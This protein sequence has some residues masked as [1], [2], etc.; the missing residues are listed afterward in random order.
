VR[1]LVL[2]LTLCCALAF[3]F[4]GCQKA[5]TDAGAGPVKGSA[6]PANAPKVADKATT[7]TKTLTD[8][9]GKKLILKSGGDTSFLK[10]AG[11][12]EYPGATAYAID[13]AGSAK[14]SGES[15][16]ESQVAQAEKVM[17]QVVL[18]TSDSLDKVQTWAKENL[19]DWKIKEIE[20]RDG[21]K[22]FE[23]S[24]KDDM[25][26]LMAFDYKTDDK[27]YIL[28]VDMSAM[29]KA[30]TEAMGQ[31]GSESGKAMGG[32]TTAPTKAADKA[33]AKKAG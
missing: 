27:R 7:E 23:A 22:G 19:K 2:A 1:Y 16:P 31:V 33:P 15:M 3:V 11:V 12:P 30:M 28:V 4:A 17:K 25:V 10:E 26:N 13:L 21:V 8:P 5:A 32:A 29:M 14:A 6:K 18:E 20:E 24:G 9:G